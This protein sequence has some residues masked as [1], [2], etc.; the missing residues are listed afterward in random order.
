MRDKE[1][2]I[3]RPFFHVSV[4]PFIF[5]SKICASIGHIVYI[6]MT[7]T[8]WLMII[9]RSYKR[10]KYILSDVN[11]PFDYIYKCYLTNVVSFVTRRNSHTDKLTPINRICIRSS[12]V[13][14]SNCKFARLI[15][16]MNNTQEKR[17]LNL[18]FYLI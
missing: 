10:G 17:I 13:S 6:G 9:Y 12:T 5:L 18:Q 3:F 2:D 1:R 11:T 8:L 14:V 4:L 15:L 7:T 16:R